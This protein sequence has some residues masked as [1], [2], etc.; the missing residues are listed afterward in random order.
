MPLKSA[1]TD[2]MVLAFISFQNETTEGPFFIL[3]YN[4]FVKL[5]AFMAFAVLY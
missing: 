4:G 3:P 5:N 2:P 1:D